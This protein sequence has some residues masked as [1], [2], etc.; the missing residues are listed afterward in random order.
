M[1]RDQLAALAGLI[2]GCVWIVFVVVPIMVFFVD[3]IANF[4]GIA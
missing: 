3:L 4:W 2:I 1:T